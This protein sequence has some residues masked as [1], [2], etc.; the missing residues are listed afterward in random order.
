MPRFHLVRVGALSQVGRFSSL[1]ATRFPRGSRVIVRTAR[2][3]EVGEVL[4][5]PAIDSNAQ[6][7]GSILRG[8]TVE[9]QL[10][11]ARLGRRRQE[12][13]DA[14]RRRL[15]ELDLDAALVDVEHLFDGRTLIFYFLGHQPPELQAVTADLAAIYDAAAQIG[16]FAELLAHGCGPGCGTEQASGEGCGSCSTGCTVAG[17]C[18]TRK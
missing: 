6:A 10:L 4:A 17:L 7:D 11:D 2:G 12:A 5:P 16:S 3:L 14:C 9:D 8:M 13:F 1:D 15:E 18:S